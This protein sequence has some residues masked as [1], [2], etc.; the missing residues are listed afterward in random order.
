MEQGRLQGITFAALY[1]PP[2]DTHATV[3]IM[4]TTHVLLEANITVPRYNAGAVSG[5]LRT[6]F[7]HADRSVVLAFYQLT[8]VHRNVRVS[9]DDLS[10]AITLKSS[11]G[12]RETY[13][14]STSGLRSA[15]THHLGLCHVPS[16]PD[17]WFADSGRVVAAELIVSYKGFVVSYGRLSGSITLHQR[18]AWFGSRLNASSADGERRQRALSTSVAINWLTGAFGEQNMGAYAALPVSPVFPEEVFTVDV[19]ANTGGFP[20]GAFQ[21]WITFNPTKVEYV[22]HATTL[23]N[24]ITLD[25]QSNELRFQAAGLLSTVS[26]SSVTGSSVHIFTVQMR[27]LAAVPDGVVS[28]VLSVFTFELVNTAGVAVVTAVP[29]F[30]LDWRHSSGPTTLSSQMLVKRPQDVGIFAHTSTGTLANTAVLTGEPATYP[31]TVV[32]TREIDTIL[33]DLEVVTHY[34]S[35]IPANIG[36]ASSYLL[37]G[38]AITVSPQCMASAADASIDVTYGT[39]S[40]LLR[41]SVYF[42]KQVQLV[43]ADPILNRVTLNEPPAPPPPLRPPTP[44]P[45]HNRALLASEQPLARRRDSDSTRRNCPVYQ[46]TTLA[47][48]VDGLD[49]TYLVAHYETSEPSVVTLGPATVV[50]GV[51]IGTALVFLP[52]ASLAANATVQ[53]SNEPVRVAKLYSNLITE[54]RWHESPPIAIEQSFGFETSV[55]MIHSMVVEGSGGRMVARAEW[56]DGA[57]QNVPEL[58]QPGVNEIN[59]TSIEPQNLITSFDAQNLVWQAEVPF[60]AMYSVGEMLHTEWRYAHCLPTTAA[61]NV[62]SLYRI[63][64]CLPRCHVLLTTA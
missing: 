43:L 17:L 30:V 53:V 23:F 64:S 6:S 1:P 4:H 58:Y 62:P 19:Y 54:A 18:P 44:P 27:M 22:A 51:S 2:P 12:L 13:E 37:A 40:A 28:H 33:Y 55:L 60:K 59:V 26:E 29:G 46:S 3:S 15:A 49:A 7:A 31:I 36:T 11:D 47:L 48:E 50:Q 9:T 32:K 39:M 25:A 38:C 45:A 16:L 52:K 42:P 35:C 57:E 61:M 24:G 10:V 20:L 41:F 5:V 14:C 34:S 8:D 21:V 63:C 56:D